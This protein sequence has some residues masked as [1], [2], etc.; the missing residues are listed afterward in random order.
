MV[1]VGKL[2]DSCG[3]LVGENTK[4]PLILWE[5]QIEPKNESSG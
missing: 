1:L 4:I 5:K 3:R 2:V